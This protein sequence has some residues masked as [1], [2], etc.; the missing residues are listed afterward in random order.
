MFVVIYISI[1]SI[2]K[3]GQPTNGCLWMYFYETIRWDHGR[4]SSFQGLLVESCSCSY[5]TTNFKGSVQDRIKNNMTGHVWAQ[6]ILGT[7]KS[8]EN[9]KIVFNYKINTYREIKVMW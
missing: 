9:I 3:R 5:A 7:T 8:P 4:P 1:L 6:P 2:L